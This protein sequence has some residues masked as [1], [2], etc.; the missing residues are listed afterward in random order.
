M[1][2]TY[3]RNGPSRKLTNEDMGRAV[4]SVVRRAN[5]LRGA[6]GLFHIPYSTLEDWVNFTKT[7][8]PAGH[9]TV[10]TVKGGGGGMP[11]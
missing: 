8:T 3:I 4:P 9:P 5:S 1:V 6:A 7:K 10:Y 2:Q 11:C